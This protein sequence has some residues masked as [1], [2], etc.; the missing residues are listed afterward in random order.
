MKKKVEP[1]VLTDEF[2]I[3]RRFRTADAF[4]VYIETNAIK[5]HISC[6][7]CLTEYC[8]KED[9]DE[10]AVAVLIN[11]S[12]KSKIQAEAE[13]LHLLKGTS[14]GHLPI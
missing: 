12:L 8:E 11:E 14:P 7:E 6:L 2:L 9:I 4:S 13:D 5:R 3:T 10:D 1:E